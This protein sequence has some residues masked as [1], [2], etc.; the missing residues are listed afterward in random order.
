MYKYTFR[1]YFRVIKVDTVS[2]I[3][4]VLSFYC[5]EIKP[6]IYKEFDFYQ[7]FLFVLRRCV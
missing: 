7:L 6:L 4:G 1:L 2:I 3:A 5:L